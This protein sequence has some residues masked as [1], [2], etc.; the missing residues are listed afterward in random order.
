MRPFQYASVK[1]CLHEPYFKSLGV[2]H[3]LDHFNLAPLSFMQN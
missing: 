1:P 2:Q 3:L